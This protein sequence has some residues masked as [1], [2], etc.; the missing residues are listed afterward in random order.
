MNKKGKE[1]KVGGARYVL[2][3]GRVVS[4]GAKRV[5]YC[6]PTLSFDAW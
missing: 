6:L 5:T 2:K 4:H 1:E 3:E